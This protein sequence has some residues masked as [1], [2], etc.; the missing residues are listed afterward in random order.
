MIKVLV[1][2][3]LMQSDIDYI[4]ER[5][6]NGVALVF[7]SSYDEAGLIEFAADADVLLGGFFSPALFEACKQLKFAQ[8]PW[9]GVDNLNFEIL[10]K[11][12]VTVCNSHSNAGVV[13][14]HAVAMLFDA[15][16]KI[17]YHD[18]LMREGNWNRLF[19]NESNP[20]SPF[21]KQIV[22]AKIG[23]IGFGAIAQQVAKML[24]GFSCTFEIF[25]RSGQLPEGYDVMFS[26]YTMDAFFSRAKQFDFVF[27]GIPLTDNTR[28]MIN[29][30]YFEAMS[31]KA[32][33]INISRG[34]VINESDLF[35]A[36]KNKT[37]GGAA[38]D[39]WYQYP[40]PNNPRVFPSKDFPFHELDNLVLSPHRAGYVDSGFP[41]LDDAI[42][43]I[44]NLAQNKA[45][46][47]VISLQTKY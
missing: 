10:E 3:K 19:P 6:V 2:K 4:Q 15:A 36:L 26:A 18:R 35:N 31:E 45:L 27:I 28:G 34:Q 38:I 41:H 32:I 42:L 44:N 30:Q 39:T 1:T 9:T 33:V 22:G 11:Y 23:L 37:I 40:S 21:S 12:Q 47:N 20:V 13:A 14:E 29:Q 7:P 16:K 25:S 46:K 17:S 8:I 5:L 24:S 43:N